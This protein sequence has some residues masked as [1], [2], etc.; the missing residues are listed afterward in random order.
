MR[1]TIVFAVFLCV[2]VTLGIMLAAPSSVAISQ[3]A[4]VW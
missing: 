2:A 3:P 4:F 1:D